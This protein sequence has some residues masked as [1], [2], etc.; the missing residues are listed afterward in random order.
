MH[1]MPIDWYL[2]RSLG[3]NPLLFVGLWSLI[4]P[5]TVRYLHCVKSPRFRDDYGAEI[6][7]R[8]SRRW[9]TDVLL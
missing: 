4:P 3:E 8:V 2:Q 9:K 7:E 6:V 5:C 1:I